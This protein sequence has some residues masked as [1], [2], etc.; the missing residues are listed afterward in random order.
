MS[1][2]VEIEGHAAF[3]VPPGTLLLD[4]CEAH[5]VPMDSACGGFAACNS[6]RVRVIAGA[7][8]LSPVRDEELPFL[9]DDDQRLG[10]QAAVCGDVA[11][12]LDPGA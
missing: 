1:P 6:C 10:C 7:A 11:L 3:E 4:A 5:G 9:D 2:R 8:H 12:R